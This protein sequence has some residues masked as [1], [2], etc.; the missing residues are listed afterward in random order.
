MFRLTVCSVTYGSP[1]LPNSTMTNYLSMPVSRVFQLHPLPSGSSYWV[2]LLCQDRE[3]AWHCSNT[4]NFTTGECRRCSSRST[5]LCLPGVPATSSAMLSARHSQGIFTQHKTN[6]GVL[7][8]RGQGKDPHFTMG[9]LIFS[10]YICPM[11]A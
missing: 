3:D 8:I 10:L 2:Y 5:E 9:K 7:H 6:R 11:V 1:S 4:V